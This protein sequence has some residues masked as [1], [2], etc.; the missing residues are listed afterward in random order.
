MKGKKHGRDWSRELIVLLLEALG[1]EDKC[2]R[3][4]KPMVSINHKIPLCKGGTNVLSNTEFLCDDCMKNVHNLDFIH[5]NRKSYMKAY[6]KWYLQT[7]PDQYK[8]QLERMRDYCS[9]HNK[10]SP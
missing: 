4:G 9:K 6:H 10:K 5:G 1:K 3:C 7:H 8:K 2:E